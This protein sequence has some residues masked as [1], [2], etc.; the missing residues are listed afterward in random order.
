MIVQ[1][2][3]I[4]QETINYCKE[5]SSCERCSCSESEC[6]ERLYY[7]LNANKDV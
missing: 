5:G 1:G 7:I 6:V 3:K 4:K 2:T